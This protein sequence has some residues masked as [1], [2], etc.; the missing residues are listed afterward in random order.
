MGLGKNIFLVFFISLFFLGCAG[1]Q[2]VSDVSIFHNLPNNLAGMTFIISPAAEGNKDDLEFKFYSKIIADFLIQKGLAPSKELAIEDKAIDYYA[3][4]EYGIDNGASRIQSVP[5]YGNTG[6]SH[7]VTNVIGNTA[8]TQNTPAT[9]PI[10][11]ATYSSQEYTRRLRLTMY[12][13]TSSGSLQQIYKGDVI[14]QG[15]SSQLLPVFPCLAQS[16]FKE[17]PGKNG[18]SAKIKVAFKTPK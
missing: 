12:E 4:L 17:F 16:L 13:K 18:S 5:I 10:G 8:Y 6:V 11:S 9:G 2:V 15:S 14:S 3:V 1:G 7:S